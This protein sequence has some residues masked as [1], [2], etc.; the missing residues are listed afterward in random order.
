MN[1]GQILVTETRTEMK[2]KS[3]YSISNLWCFWQLIEIS[4]YETLISLSASLLYGLARCSFF[5]HKYF[6]TSVK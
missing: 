6:I 2:K 4:C 5:S 3:V 1:N